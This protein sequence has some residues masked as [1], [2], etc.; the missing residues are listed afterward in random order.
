MM[1]ST[2]PA[3]SNDNRAGKSVIRRLEVLAG[4]A[5]FFGKLL[6]C[7]KRED[8]FLGRLAQ[9]LAQQSPVDMFFVCFDYRVVI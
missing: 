7:H 2:S 5:R 9:V 6:E 1:C 3:L 8:P 4:T